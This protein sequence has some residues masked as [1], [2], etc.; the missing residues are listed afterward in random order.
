MR[1]GARDDNVHA[2]QP[3]HQLSRQLADQEDGG[4]VGEAV[5]RAG[6]P[7]RS[8]G[9]GFAE[10][11]GLLGRRRAVHSNR[12]C[13]RGGQP[14][15]AW[16][17]CVGSRAQQRLCKPVVAGSCRGAAGGALWA[18][19]APRSASLHRGC[20]LRRRRCAIRL[21]RGRVSVSRA[22]GQGQPARF[23]E[24]PFFPRDGQRS[25]QIQARPRGVRH[26]RREKLLRRRGL[27][28]HSELNKSKT[29]PGGQQL[30]GTT[31]L[32]G[33]QV[34]GMQGVPGHKQQE[35]VRDEQDRA[36]SPGGAFRRSGIGASPAGR[37][38]SGGGV[39]ADGPVLVLRHRDAIHGC[40][41]ETSSLVR[42]QRT[43]RP[44][45][46]DAAD[47]AWTGQARFRGDG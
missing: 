6:V 44:D 14:H 22:P 17:C 41:S 7:H 32:E 25:R 36:A 29:A 2:A 3:V 40:R 28:P 13:P 24:H 26:T 38:Y 4:G 33:Q 1:G 18:R 37:W 8:R 47:Y 20:V 45:D 39:V 11:V 15:A 9:S 31:Q 12:K 34:W 46:V 35:A 5:F 16:N 43:R 10:E 27:Y 19:L 23:R 21:G 30:H 42:G